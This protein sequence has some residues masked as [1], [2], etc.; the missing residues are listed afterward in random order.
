MLIVG[1]QKLRKIYVPFNYKDKNHFFR[2][3]QKWEN[4]PI[5]C[6]LLDLSHLDNNTNYGPGLGRLNLAL[7]KLYSALSNQKQEFSTS[8]NHGVWDFALKEQFSA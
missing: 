5:M 4:K 8:P 7:N 1:L 2:Y 3:L 6:I